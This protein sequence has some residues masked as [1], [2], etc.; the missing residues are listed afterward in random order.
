MSPVIEIDEFLSP[1]QRV[2]RT[3]DF[4]SA[5]SIVTRNELMF[6]RADT[7]L[8]KNEGI[9]RLLAQLQVTGLGNCG[10]M[11]WSNRQSAQAIHE[12]VKRSY[13]IS[14]WSTNPE[15]VAMWSLYSPD[16]CS[17]RIRASVASLSVAVNNIM[18]KYSL[19][20]LTE[21]D[22]NKRVV[23]AVSSRIAPV[24]YASLHYISERIARRAK[25]RI[26]LTERYARKQ[27]RMPS[28]NE[29]DPKYWL[30][31]KQRAFKELQT[32][33]NL[34]DI[35][36]Q[37]EAE[38]RLAIRFAEETCDSRMLSDIALLN[39]NHLHREIIKRGLG[40]WDF[41]NKTSMPEREF[42]SCPANTID[43]VAIDPRCPPHKASF[44]QAWFLARGI[45]VVNS[46]CF[47]Y[48]PNHFSVY[49]DA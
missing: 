29:V 23:V 9:D 18:E 45:R 6:S 22:I 44:M 42:A 8:D 38:I 13:L 37:H 7:F 41:L 14:C 40:Y 43:E 32:S 24:A 17:V 28:I 48:L 19:D 11:G 10:G 35:S 16:M 15:S 21:A 49:P 3:L 4:Y 31:E 2:Y 20:R 30:R 47:G 36:F 39:T 12:R 33:C 26:R 34:K 25:S 1:N 27:Q 46:T 5:A